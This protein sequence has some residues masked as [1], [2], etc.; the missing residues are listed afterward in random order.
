MTL[1]EIK[2]PVNERD[3]AFLNLKNILVNA[4]VSSEYKIK[5]L[6]ALKSYITTVKI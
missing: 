3:E 1:E 5:M 4:P 6:E 2:P